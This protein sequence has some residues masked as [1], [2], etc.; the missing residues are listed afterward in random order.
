MVGE[1][2]R[3]AI[4]RFCSRLCRAR[5]IGTPEVNAKKAHWGADHPRFL[6]I[7]TRRVWN[8]I[9][10]VMVKTETGWEREHRVVAGAPRQPRNKPRLVVHHVDGDPTNNTPENLMKVS[11]S[12]HVWLHDERERD[13]KGR[14]R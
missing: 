2:R 14:F 11:Q 8:G 5:G 3:V 7:G 13:D 9:P 12:L 10:G 6:P 1:K 4:S